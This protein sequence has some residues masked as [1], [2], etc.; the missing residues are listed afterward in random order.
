[1][2]HLGANEPARPRSIVMHLDARLCVGRSGGAVQQLGTVRCPCGNFQNCAPVFFF[3]L[4]VAFVHTSHLTH[5]SLPY[6]DTI[7][8]L[9]FVCAAVWFV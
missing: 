8:V 2:P 9:G 4:L 6:T 7:V 5:F 1:M 3:F